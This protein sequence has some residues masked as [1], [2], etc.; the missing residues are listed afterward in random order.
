MCGR[1]SVVDNFG[2][3]SSLT[4]KGDA[5]NISGGGC[6]TVREEQRV[7]QSKMAQGRNPVGWRAF[8]A[9]PSSVCAPHVG[10]G[11]KVT[12]VHVAVNR[13]RQMVNQADKRPAWA[14]AVID[15]I[16]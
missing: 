3:A 14:I 15:A 10:P 13:E 6:A 5:V 9:L 7:N 2:N 8:S 16:D 11:S 1:V 12:R 4:P